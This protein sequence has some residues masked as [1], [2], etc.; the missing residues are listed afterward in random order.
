MGDMEYSVGKTI[1]FSDE[2]KSENLLKLIGE[3]LS[4]SV[5]RDFTRVDMSVY[6]NI[7]LEYQGRLKV[8][9]GSSEQLSYKLECFKA[10]VGDYLEE[11]TEGT[12]DLE[13]L[14]YSPK[15]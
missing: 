14:T 3:F 8:R 15:K 10:I 9:V 13:R 12:L 4:D 5:G 2:K 6:D 1:K 11:G 7:T